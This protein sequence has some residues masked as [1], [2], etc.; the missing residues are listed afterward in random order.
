MA[1]GIQIQ[2]ALYGTDSTTVDVTSNVAAHLK[3]GSLNV[4]VSPDGLN[5]TDPAPG[6]QKTL[7]V[8]YTINF[9][10][11]NTSMTK[12][13]D[14]LLINAPPEREAD[15]L[16]IIKA[17][18]GYIGNFTD[19]T[20]AIQ[21]HVRDGSIN[22]KVS[23]TS[24]GIPDPNPNKPKSLQ[25]EYSLN[26]APNMISVNDGQTFKVSAPPLDGSA[27]DVKQNMYNLSGSLGSNIGWLFSSFF[28]T[29]GICVGTRLIGLSKNIGLMM[30][31]AIVLSL[32]SSLGGGGF[33][34]N[35]IVAGSVYGL[36]GTIYFFIGLFTDRPLVT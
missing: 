25:V 21:T 14:V 10:K 34:V 23:P 16:Q 29:M 9:G 36:I 6:Q 32:F 24:A 26:G 22:L 18:Y 13:G 28:L 19:V 11:I 8:S 17:E 33:I 1:S 35:F 5:V 31:S 27:S 30:S 20:D 12:D 15:G 4:V 7:T 3:D 2:K